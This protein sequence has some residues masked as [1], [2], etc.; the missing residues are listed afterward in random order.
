[1]TATALVATLAACTPDEAPP[2]ATAAGT[3]TP[4][5]TPV[6]ATEAEALAA[7]ETAYTG[8]TRASDA[9]AQSSGSEP[10]RLTKWVTK[11]WWDVEISDAKAWRQSG[12][13][14]QGRTRFFDLDI[15][16]VTPTQ[17]GVTVGA[18]VCVDISHTKLL[19]RSGADITPADRAD[20]Y[21]LELE[22][23]SA[24]P[25]T[26]LVLG[27]SEPWSNPSRCA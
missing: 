24:T 25:A 26:R 22:F 19:N 5:A 11:D 1:M 23:S 14:L 6:F 4:T 18:Y 13:R 16:R 8:Y 10:E 12:E 27:R 9:V 2:G 7:V 21:A 15:Q 3:P 17:S 20:V